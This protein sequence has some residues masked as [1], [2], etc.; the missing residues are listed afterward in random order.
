LGQRTGWLGQQETIASLVGSL[1]TLR[2]TW[3]VSNLAGTD[4]VKKS[5]TGVRP[6][7]ARDAHAK[8]KQHQ[9]HLNPFAC[10]INTQYDSL[11]DCAITKIAPLLIKTRGNAV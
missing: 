6:M 11:S 8:I 2:G 7:N 1:K 9:Y 10:V 3:V 5:G 4:A